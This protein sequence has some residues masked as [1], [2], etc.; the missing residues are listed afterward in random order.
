MPLV[1]VCAAG[2]AVCTLYYWLQGG[3][4][5]RA[6]VF[7]ALTAISAIFAVV[8][9]YGHGAAI[10]LIGV[11]LAWPVSGLPVYYWRHRLRNASLEMAL[12]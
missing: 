12:R 3:W 5:A 1:I 10:L 11:C 2:S 8:N 9:D 6:L 7:I 4:F